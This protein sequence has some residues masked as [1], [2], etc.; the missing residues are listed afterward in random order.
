MLITIYYKLLRQLLPKPLKNILSPLY[1]FFKRCKFFVKYKF[2]PPPEGTDLAGYE[3]LLD[4]LI[5]RKTLDLKGDLLEIGA[6]LGGG[7]YKLSKIVEKFAPYKKV[8]VV[9]IFDPNFDTTKCIFGIEMRELYKKS[10][11]RFG[12]VSQETIFLQVT[13]TCKNIVVIK[14]DSKCVDLPI[15]HLCFAFIDG[16]HDPSYVEND[17]YLAWN[18]LV[19]G[20]AVAFDDYDYDLPQ[21]TETINMLIQ[22]HKAEISEIV[23][24]GKK[25]IVLIKK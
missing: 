23:R 1:Y 4:F 7:T 18:R 14:G 12:N 22:R 6:F 25:I 5:D 15:K 3:V 21:V 24:L 11:E 10:L 9:D 17:F 13:K 2:W 20:G 16:N 19:S 8:Y